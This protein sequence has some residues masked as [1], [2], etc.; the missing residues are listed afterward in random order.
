MDARRGALSAS[1]QI[2]GVD[3]GR[4]GRRGQ[5]R[6]R[7]Q[8]PA[9]LAQN[10]LVFFIVE[11]ERVVAG[12]GQPLPAAGNSRGAERGRRGTG[13]GG[14]AQEAIQIDLC[15]RRVGQALQ[16]GGRIVGKLSRAPRSGRGAGTG[17]GLPSG[18]QA[19]LFGSGHQAE[20]SFRQT[21]RL[22]AGQRA[23]QGRQPF[24]LQ[25]AFKQAGVP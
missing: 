10:P 16:P 13:A 5:W 19:D 11:A 7:D 18:S 17:A 12:H 24:A 2:Q 15:F 21:P 6:K 20:L 1:A 25:R 4:Q 14:Q 3:P 23:E 8:F 9:A 22:V